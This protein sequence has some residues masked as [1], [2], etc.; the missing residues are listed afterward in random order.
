MD[1]A[2]VLCVCVSVFYV[3]A[4][5]FLNYVC[6]S[7]QQGFCVCSSVYPY[8][9]VFVPADTVLLCFLMLQ[10][11]DDQSN[12]THTCVF[13]FECVFSQQGFSCC[14]PADWRVGAGFSYHSNL[15]IVYSAPNTHNYA[16]NTYKVH[17]SSFPTALFLSC[18]N[19]FLLT[20][21]LLFFSSY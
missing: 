14:N 4:Q 9:C 13:L 8:W 20:V 21:S 15:Y 12:S 3:S 17:L 6:A 7:S 5:A 11:T 2:G 19:V 10:G 16:L 18:S 1:S